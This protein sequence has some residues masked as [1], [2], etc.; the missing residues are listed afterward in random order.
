MDFTKLENNLIDTI[1]EAQIKLG[2]E[3]RPMS[4]NY[5]LSSLNH[6]TG[7]SRNAAEMQVLLKEFCETVTERLGEIEV[8][9][10]Q[11]MFCL[12]I[13]AK[14][15]D[16]VH[17]HCGNGGFIA[18]LINTVRSNGC[19]LDEATAVFYRYSDKVCVKESDNAEFDRLVYFEDGVPDSYRY[20]LASEGMRI[21]YHR[22][23]KE[24]YDAFGF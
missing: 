14:G 23:T 1:Q 21:T 16:Y 24:D 15:S 9:P 8:T 10:V 13:P 17:E 19:T 11:T 6:L 18:E 2:Y 4:L 3:S 20:C 7:G 12:K 5:A 22:F